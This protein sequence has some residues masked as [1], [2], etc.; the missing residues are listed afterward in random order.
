MRMC[1]CKYHCRLEP[2][3]K[4]IV[5]G[6]QTSAQNIAC[7]YVHNVLDGVNNFGDSYGNDSKQILA[8]V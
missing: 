2:W 6:F 3:G 1:A 5:T 8:E 7:S 4:A